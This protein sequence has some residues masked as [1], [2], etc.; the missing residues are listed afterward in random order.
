MVGGGVVGAAEVV[1]VVEVVM[2]IGVGVRGTGRVGDTA[3]GVEDRAW[4]G[5][6]VING[7]TVGVSVMEEG[8]GRLVGEEVGPG[9]RVEEL[10][11][12]VGVATI[13][14]GR[15]DIVEVQPITVAFPPETVRHF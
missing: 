7:S 2:G 3:V 9:D 10:W 8:V 13:P 4:L 15:R 1:V 14:S 12:Y 5:E 11:G 6:A